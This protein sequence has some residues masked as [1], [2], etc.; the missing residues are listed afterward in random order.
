MR[1][2]V[3]G[4]SAQEICDRIRAS[5]ICDDRDRSFLIKVTGAWL[6]NIFIS[7]RQ[8]CPTVAEFVK[9]AQSITHFSPY[10]ENKSSASNWV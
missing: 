7:S 10:T 9:M 6:M 4:D 3:R 8:H 5:K 1:K 2:K